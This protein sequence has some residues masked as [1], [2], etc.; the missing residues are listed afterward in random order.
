MSEWTHPLRQNALVRRIREDNCA[1]IMEVIGRRW[2][3][4]THEWHYEITCPTHTG[5]H[6][7][8]QE[9]FEDV[10]EDTGHTNTEVKPVMIEWVRRECYE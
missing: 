6:V 2:D 5:Y 9:D 4:D 10:F 8:A 7:Y 1:K 3:I